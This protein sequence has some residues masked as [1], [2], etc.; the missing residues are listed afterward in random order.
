MTSLEADKEGTS[1]IHIQLSNA[2]QGEEYLKENDVI[3]NGKHYVT[4]NLMAPPSWR[5]NE[6][7][8]LPEMVI[9]RT[10]IASKECQLHPKSKDEAPSK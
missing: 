2:L 4:L 3:S 9:H 8:V 7:D 10:T 5:V 1:R 6:V